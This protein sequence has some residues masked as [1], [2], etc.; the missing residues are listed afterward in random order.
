MA[1]L[2]CTCFPCRSCRNRIS[3][4]LVARYPT[5]RNTVDTK[6][7]WIPATAGVSVFQS[8]E[9]IRALSASLWTIFCTGAASADCTRARRRLIGSPRLSSTLELTSTDLIRSGSLR[10]SPRRRA[11]RRDVLLRTE[12]D[13]DMIRNALARSSRTSVSRS[14]GARAQVSD[15]RAHEGRCAAARIDKKRK[16]NCTESQASAVQS[17]AS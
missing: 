9:S 16:G 13:P 3:I 11:G 7:G 8:A 17:T 1:V 2:L 6:I 14:A 15:W 5:F 12:V 10:E 4:V